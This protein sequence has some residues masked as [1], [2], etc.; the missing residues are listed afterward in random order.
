MRRDEPHDVIASMERDI[1]ILCINRL[2]ETFS[3][4]IRAMPRWPESIG[5]DDPDEPWDTLREHL[6]AFGLDIEQVEEMALAVRAERDREEDE[7]VRRQEA[8][9]KARADN[10]ARDA[11]RAWN[12]AAKGTRSSKGCRERTV[13]FPRVKQV[14]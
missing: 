2:R 4:T 12:A 11:L 10:L 8:N 13:S 5:T 7:V 1:C 3:P 14:P 6:H 9:R